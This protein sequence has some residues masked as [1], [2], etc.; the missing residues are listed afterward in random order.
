MRMPV[1]ALASVLLLGLGALPASG[2][3]PRVPSYLILRAPAQVSHGQPY[4]PGRGYE[5]K[6]QAY[7][8]GWFG[9]QPRSH[10]HRQTGYYS[11]YIQWSKR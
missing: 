10:W 5:V 11:A 4:H 2:Q 1:L 8:Y 9:A 6:P 7:A 3:D